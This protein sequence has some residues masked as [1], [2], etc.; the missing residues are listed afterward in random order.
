MKQI[1][2]L[3][4]AVIAQI[5]AGQVVERPVSI[6]KELVENSLDADARNITIKVTEGGKEKIS[7]SDDGH[8]MS[9]DD[10]ALAIQ[11]HTTNKIKTTQDLL[12]INTLG[13]RG[14]ALYSITQAA[15]LIIQSRTSSQSMGTKI[16]LRNGIVTAQSPVGMSAG[17]TILIENIFNALPARKKFLKSTNIEFQLLLESV[18]Q[19]ALAHPKVGFQL[20]HNNQLVLDI[21]PHTNFTERV[22]A[23]FGKSI[24]SLFL[25]LSLEVSDYK[26]YGFLG[27]PQA[28]TTVSQSQF[29]I[30]NNRPVVSPKISKV[31][32]RL[33]K[34]LLP[35]GIQPPFILYLELH[36]ESIDVNI[37]P[38]KREV[39]FNEEELLL[40]VLQTLIRQTLEKANLIFSMTDLESLT[41]NDSKM[42]EGTA[43]I[44]RDATQIWNVKEFF[45]EEPVMQINNLYLIAQTTE[46]MLVIDQHAAHERILY[47]Q[48]LETFTAQ[49]SN[50]VALIKFIKI[51]LPV[52][53]SQ[54]LED[55]RE[56]FEKLGF[57]FTK[58]SS[59][60]FSFSQ[61]PELLHT[62]KLEQ[63]ILEVLRDIKDQVEVAEL[64]LES[65]RTIAYLAC[66]GAIKA[67]EVL[68][69]QERKN[70]V[71]KLL[72]T[73]SKY[74]CPHGRPVLIHI[75]PIDL[76]K[77]FYRIP[78]FRN[79]K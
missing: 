76:A 45:E 43:K 58:I 47:E 10:L 75:T 26:I 71:S 2:Q 46:G 51:A 1:I 54:L 39:R 21:L 14:E 7:I 36:P 78:A 62:R 56:V 70:I 44:L 63:Y 9:A 32:R 79:E 20:F 13:F 37:H 74:T 30:V 11:A 55:N 57:V 3:P 41:L 66:R 6:V 22:T 12:A 52:L 23:A 40:Q 15:D 72:L 68:T 65:H 77:M 34:T 38:Q 8:G 33:F 64:D 42:D 60:E 59:T 73:T 29:L 31:I 17:T 67:G 24:E 16:V 50:K 49:K 4:A 27:T 35:P 19:L 61:I 69:P 25:P 53:E 18:T 48:F 5:A 28:A